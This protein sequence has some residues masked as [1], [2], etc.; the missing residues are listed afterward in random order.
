MWPETV[1]RQALEQRGWQEWDD[2]I[3]LCPLED[4]ENVPDG[5]KMTSIND[6]QVIKGQDKI[7]LDTRG[8]FLAYGI[9]L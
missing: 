3:L 6:H 5:T 4:F 2:H 7:N 1:N 9:Q 8:K